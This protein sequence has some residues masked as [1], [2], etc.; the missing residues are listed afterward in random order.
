MLRLVDS[1]SIATSD[2]TLGNKSAKHP[3][4]STG[5][6]KIAQLYWFR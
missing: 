4:I 2:C 5:V 3:A 6:E 1:I